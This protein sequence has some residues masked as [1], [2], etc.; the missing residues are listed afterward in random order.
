MFHFS[1]YLIFYSGSFLAE[2]GSVRASLYRQ[3]VEL[4]DLILDGYRTQLQTIR[5]ED[6]KMAV[7]FKQYEKDR[8]ALILPLGTTLFL[9]FLSISMKI[10]RSRLC[11]SKQMI[12]YIQFIT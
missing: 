2:D 9:T 5:N 6:R 11:E 4:C 8:S 1:T 10:S 3:L 12:N 7:V